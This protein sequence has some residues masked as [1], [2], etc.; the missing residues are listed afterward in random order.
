[1]GGLGFSYYKNSREGETDH[2]LVYRT[3]PLSKSVKTFFEREWKHPCIVMFS[4]V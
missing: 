1:L 4:R 2:I 3:F